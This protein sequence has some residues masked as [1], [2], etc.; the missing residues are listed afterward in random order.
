MKKQLVIK[1]IFLGVLLCVPIFGLY[2]IKDTI[3]NKD[4]KSTFPTLEVVSEIPIPDFSFVNQNNEIITNET[5]KGKIYIA[6]FIFTTCPTIC[7]KIGFLEF[8]A[9][10][11]D[12][13]P[14][15]GNKI[16]YTSGWPKNQNKC[17]NKIGL[18]P[19]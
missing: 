1:W 15:A 18:P 14:S 8:T 12:T 17:S 10:T 13:I 16:I 11:S 2:L 6:D 3:F 9:I 19:A 5:Y 4:D 7:P